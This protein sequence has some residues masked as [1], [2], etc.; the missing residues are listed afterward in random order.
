MEQ[1]LPLEEARKMCEQIGV[2][3]YDGC[4]GYVLLQDGSRACFIVLPESSTAPDPDTD[5]Y[6]R[7]ERAHCNGWPANHSAE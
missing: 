3:P 4:A 7:H 6:F 2:G 5:H 1:V